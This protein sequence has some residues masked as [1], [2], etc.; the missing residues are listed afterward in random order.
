MKKHLWF[1][2]ISKDHKSEFSGVADHEQN[3]Q[4]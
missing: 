3:F 2:E 1:E 4:S